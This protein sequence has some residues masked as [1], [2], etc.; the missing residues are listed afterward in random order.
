LTACRAGAFRWTLW[1]RILAF[2]GSTWAGC[3]TTLGAD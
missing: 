3:D 2:F 1:A